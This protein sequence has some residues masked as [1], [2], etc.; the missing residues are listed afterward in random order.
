MSLLST[1]QQVPIRSFKSFKFLV[2]RKRNPDFSIFPLA[3]LPFELTFLAFCECWLV[4]EFSTI[5]PIQLDSHDLIEHSQIVKKNIKEKNEQ[6]NSDTNPIVQK[7]NF[8]EKTKVQHYQHYQH[9]QLLALW[10][11]K[12]QTENQKRKQ[13]TQISKTIQNSNHFFFFTFIFF[14][15]FFF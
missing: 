10:P 11:S 5:S 1:H 8:L 7:L 12:C 13:A 15:F 3:Y 4:L 9:Y 6:R 2:T 14:I